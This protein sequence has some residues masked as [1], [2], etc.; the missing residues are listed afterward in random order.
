MIPAHGPPTWFLYDL[1]FATFVTQSLQCSLCNTIF[2]MH[3]LQCNLCN[4]TFATQPLQCNI[5]N[6]IFTT[7]AMQCNLC[8][9]IFAVGCHWFS[10]IFIYF[11]RFSL[12]L[13]VFFIDFRWFAL[14]PLIFIHCHWLSLISLILIGF[15]AFLN[16]HWILYKLHWFLLFPRQKDAGLKIGSYLPCIEL[17]WHS[18]IARRQGT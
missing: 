2:A 11:H 9:P 14:V 3:S 4:T 15:V 18:R 7:Q 17:P 12:I 16:F 6:A 5:C 8:N 1:C 10:L 13:I